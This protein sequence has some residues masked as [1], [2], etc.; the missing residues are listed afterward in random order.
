[1]LKESRKMA[2]KER[3]Q[4]AKDEKVLKPIRPSAAITAEYQRRLDRLITEMNASVVYFLTAS[5]RRNEPRTIAMDETPAD[6]LRRTMRDLA[7]R[8]LAKFDVAS[9]KLGEW[10]AQSVENRST[11]QLKKI[12]RDGGIA[13]DFQMT[14]GM[15]DVMDATVNAN[16]ALIKSIPAK[17]FSEIE[18]MV[19]RSVQ[20]GRDIGQLSD[21]LQKR[22]GI[23]KRRAAFIATDQNEKA[24]SAFN[25]VRMLEAGITHA[26]WQHSGGGRDKRPTHVKASRDKV[27]YPIS[28]GWF[29]PAV[30]EKIQP[31]YLPRCK[32]IGRPIVKGFS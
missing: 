23:T 6:A 31:G 22:F 9:V 25:R 4:K 32:C 28:E 3:K 24:T 27:I 10:F 12:L 8:W 19:Q 13:V 29:D 14:P 5:Y 1:M 30:G 2:S 20:T 16:V 7:K 21:D 18:D 11:T 15:R 26:Q 17:Y